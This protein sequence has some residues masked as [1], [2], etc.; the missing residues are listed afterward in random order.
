ME[1]HPVPQQISSYQFRLVGDMTLKQFF[2]LAGGVVV[3]IIFYATKLPFIIKW[4]LII[5]FVLFGAALAFLPIEERPLEQWIIAFFR[6]IYSPTQYT[7][8][9]IGERKYFQD[10]AMQTPEPQQELPLHGT[11]QPSASILS[12][13]KKEESVLGKIAGLFQSTKSQPAILSSTPTVSQEAQIV[14]QRK[15]LAT[16]PQEAPTMVGVSAGVAGPVYQPAKVSV[17]VPQSQNEPQLS[18]VQKVV[19]EAGTLSGQNAQFSTQ[20]APPNPPTQPNIVVGQIIGASGEIVDKAILEIR[21]EQGRPVRALRSNEVGH[22]QIVTP[23]LNGKY[24]LIAEKQGYKFF[25]VV[26]E[27]KGDVIPPIAIR[28]SKTEDIGGP[29]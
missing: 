18:T 23:L 27:A 2:E 3:A 20:A 10:E 8:R 11:V 24:E 29:K 12:L 14:Q 26:F 28:A 6:S 17:P 13:E 4:P 15:P 21:D 7:W 19:Q 16:V 5:F 22:F 1:Q 9:K 25:P